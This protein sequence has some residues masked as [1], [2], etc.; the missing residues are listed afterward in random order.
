MHAQENMHCSM[1]RFLF[2]ESVDGGMYVVVEPKL[3]ENNQAYLL[4]RDLYTV[5]S[6]HGAR[7]D[8]YEKTSMF[9]L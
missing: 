3:S 8:K 7:A 5:L 4:C 6:I 2:L 9:Y 1:R